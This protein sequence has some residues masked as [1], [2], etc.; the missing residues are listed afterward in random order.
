[1]SKARL[2]DSARVKSLAFKQSA[3][4][5]RKPCA[6]SATEIPE[7]ERFGA[8]IPSVAKSYAWS[9]SGPLMRT[10]LNLPAEAINGESQMVEGNDG[11]DGDS[12]LLFRVGVD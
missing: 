11:R 8:S 4:N 3:S 1:M 10:L 12:S 2:G 9:A 6:T 7:I 5:S